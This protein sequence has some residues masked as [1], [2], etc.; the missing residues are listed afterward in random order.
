MRTI[1]V[2][3][4]AA[5]VGLPAVGAPAKGGV[6]VAEGYPAWT[7]VTPQNHLDGREIL[8]PS[9]LRQRITYIVEVD[10]EHAAEQLEI[11]GDLSRRNFS[12]NT[13]TERGENW[14]T[15]KAMPH[16]PL[17]VYVVRNLKPKDKPTFR[18]TIRPKSSTDT[19]GL[20]QIESLSAPVYADITFDGAPDN[21]GKFPFVYVMGYEGTEPIW[22]GTFDANARVLMDRAVGPYKKAAAE[23]GLAWRPYFG[24]VAE[25]THFTGLP[26]LLASEKP[27]DGFT[28]SLLKGIVSKDPEVAKEAQMLYDGLEQTR[29]DYIMLATGAMKPCPH[30]AAYFAG[31]AGKRWPKAR[32]RLANVLTAVKTNAE[33]KPLV[34]MFAKIAQWSDPNF[35]CKNAGEAKKIVAELTKMK[36]ALE[37]LKENANNITVQNGALTLDGLVDTL[38]ATIPE[39]VEQK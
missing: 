32:K 1:A 11:A 27:V 8:S 17:V 30:A 20:W 18:R 16:E 3:V 33:A 2:V 29:D 9:Y 14:E 22:K 34:V 36:K 5:L 28:A 35:V 13:F 12:A 7:G 10:A 38:I 21:G 31:V 4:L 6:P 23:K 25:P 39:K 37:P 19:P 24:F 15:L 26:A